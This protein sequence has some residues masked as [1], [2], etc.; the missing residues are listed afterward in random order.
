MVK[1]GINYTLTFTWYRYAFSSPLYYDTVRERKHR[2]GWKG[3]KFV[4]IGIRRNENLVIHFL[5]ESEPIF[6]NYGRK[7]FRCR[8]RSEIYILYLSSIRSPFDNGAEKIQLYVH[9]PVCLATSKGLRPLFWIYPN[10]VHCKAVVCDSVPWTEV[11]SETRP[12]KLLL[13]DYNFIFDS[14]RRDMYCKVK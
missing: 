8:S 1:K 9:L 2:S 11:S 10:I 12:V 14:P 5:V 4:L 13:C 6:L 3:G 7:R